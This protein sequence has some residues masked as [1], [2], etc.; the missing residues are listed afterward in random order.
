[1]N[2]SLRRLFNLQLA[3]FQNWVRTRYFQLS[4]FNILILILVLL[5]SA[6]YFEP[7]F[8][9]TINTIVL[10]GLI[11]S[12]FL[13]GVRS[14]L[15]FSVALTFWVFASLLKTVKIDVWAERTSVYF[16]QAFI[17]GVVLLIIGSIKLS[18]VNFNKKAKVLRILLQFF[19]VFSFQLV[20]LKDLLAGNKWTKAS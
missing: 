10:L 3:N 20:R 9:I 16:F 18:L 19:S 8:P 5:R 7:F 2:Q 6:G 11:I 15:M 4:L 14:K 1:M 12:V 13:L 17:I